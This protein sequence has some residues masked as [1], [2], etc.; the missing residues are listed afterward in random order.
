MKRFGIFLL[1]AALAVAEDKPKTEAEAA[2]ERLA[3]AAML[4]REFSKSPEQ[5]Q[6]E[7]LERAA[8]EVK[9][10]WAEYERVRPRYVAAPMPAQPAYTPP[11]MSEGARPY[12]NIRNARPGANAGQGGTY[13]EHSTRLPGGTLQTLTSDGRQCYTYTLPGPNGGTLYTQCY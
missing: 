13:T 11:A 5:V 6:R 7:R 1:L 4:D 12:Y 10:Y 3:V 9:A 8:A 2:R